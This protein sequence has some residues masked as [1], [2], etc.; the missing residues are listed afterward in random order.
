MIDQVA[1]AEEPFPISPSVDSKLVGIR[2]WLIL[3][4]IGL[5][6]GIIANV[7]TLIALF[8]MFSR[9]THY[10]DSTALVFILS[11]EG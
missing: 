3:P 5:V 1:V 4:A 6:V 7:V 11:V 2:G 9:L 10:D 8:V